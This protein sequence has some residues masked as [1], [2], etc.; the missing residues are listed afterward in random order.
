MEEGGRDIHRDCVVSVPPPLKRFPENGVP[1]RE[2]FL[3][4]KLISEPNLLLH[5]LYLTYFEWSVLSAVS[6]KFVSFFS[7][8][9]LYEAQFGMHI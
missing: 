3:L 8:S 9:P 6:K 5:L 1:L 7:V 4:T 2:L